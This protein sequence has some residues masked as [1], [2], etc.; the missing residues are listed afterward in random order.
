M[1]LFLVSNV[2]AQ[3]DLQVVE[4]EDAPFNLFSWLKNVLK[5]YFLDFSIVGDAR[6]CSSTADKR[7]T[8]LQGG[9]Y[10]IVRIADHCRSGYGLIDSYVNGWNPGTEFGGDIGYI[11]KPEHAPCNLEVYCCPYGWCEYLGKDSYCRQVIGQ[12]SECKISTEKDPRIKFNFNRWSYCTDDIS[13]TCWFND[14]SGV[15]QSRVYTGRTTCPYSYMDWRLYPTKSQCESNACVD[16]NKR[17]KSSTVREYCY[18]GQWHSASCPSGTTCSNGDC[19]SSPPQQQCSDGTPYNS[20]ASVKPKYCDN[21]NLINKCSTCGCLV[22]QTCL[23]DGSCCTP[24]TCAKLGFTCGST[25]NGCGGTLNCGNCPTGQICQSNICVLEEQPVCTH[26]EKLCDGY[27]KYQCQNNEWIFIEFNSLD[28]GYT[29]PPGEP[30]G[31]PLPP[32]PPKENFLTV[33]V[34][35]INGFSVQWWMLLV[36]VL[37]VLI[38]IK[39]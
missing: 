15:C 29:A 39:R 20:C 8:N 21:G 37:V 34:F 16:G 13:V 10:T 17:C 24:H 19:V 9:S 2:S 22:G 38:I 23:Q 27:T 12:G 36:A 33:E 18:L 4:S 31:Q 26:G 28:C 32:S 5:I 11:C 7:F 25:N 1:V 35:N 30:G 6:G 3:L 14:G